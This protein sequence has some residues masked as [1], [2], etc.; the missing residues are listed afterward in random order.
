MIVKDETTNLGSAALPILS[1]RFGLFSWDVVNDRF[2]ADA[3]VA[4]LFA[5]SP[6]S[7]ASG[8]P[9][10]RLLDCLHTDDRRRAARSLHTTI[11]SGRLCRDTYRVRIRRNSYREIVAVARCFGYSEGLPTTCSGLLCDIEDCRAATSPVAHC[12][13]NVVPFK[14]VV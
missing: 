9:I 2:C 1:D 14:T 8:L 7:L 4:R 13:D 11:T 3:E 6:N 12:P 10:E 5:L